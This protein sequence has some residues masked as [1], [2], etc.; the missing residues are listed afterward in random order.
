MATAAATEM[1]AEGDHMRRRAVLC[2]PEVLEALAWS[3]RD[4]AQVDKG[5]TLGTAGS[6]ER[7]N[8]RQL[9]AP[10]RGT[11]RIEAAVGGGR[12]EQAEGRGG[13]RVVAR[14][15]Y[16]IH[17]VRNGRVCLM[18][19]AVVDEDE[20]GEMDMDDERKSVNV[21]SHG[22]VIRLNMEEASAGELSVLI[23][24]GRGGL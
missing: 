23:G 1:A 19:L 22:Q 15:E 13:E 21:I 14:V 3:V 10:C 16:C 9:V 7:G 11:R 5:Q 6:I 2:A 12:G 4:G 20:E 17:P 24:A 18:C 8:L